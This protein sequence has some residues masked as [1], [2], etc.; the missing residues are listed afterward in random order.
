MDQFS[1]YRILLSYFIIASILSM[2]PP[3]MSLGDSVGGP[4]DISEPTHTN[5][6][7]GYVPMPMM[8]G[9]SM[10]MGISSGACLVNVLL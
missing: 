5:T 8:V 1:F 6:H 4:M 2:L 10:G 7:Q 3:L 9:F